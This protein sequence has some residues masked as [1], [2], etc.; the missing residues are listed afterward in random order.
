[1]Q[2]ISLALSL[3]AVSKVFYTTE[4]SD[5]AHPCNHINPPFRR[6]LAPLDAN[7][8]NVSLFKPAKP[9]PATTAVVIDVS[10]VAAVD[11]V[12]LG[13]P[14]A[15]PLPPPSLSDLLADNSPPDAAATAHPI[16]PSGGAPT[17]AVSGGP[18]RILD[19]GAPTPAVPPSDRRVALAILGCPTH[20]AEREVP[21]MAPT[22]HDRAVGDQRRQGT[23]VVANNGDESFG[24]ADTLQC[25][26]P[27]KRG[28][29]MDL[30]DVA[31]LRDGL[32]GQD[33]LGKNNGC[34]RRGEV[35]QVWPLSLGSTFVCPY[36]SRTPL[37]HTFDIMT[38]AAGLQA[39]PAL[40]PPLQSSGRPSVASAAVPK[41]K[42][43]GRAVDPPFP[44]R[45]WHGWS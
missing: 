2:I 17:P 22:A 20:T 25:Y 11:T 18:P 34:I 4:T 13:T 15:M 37:C 7:A 45:R 24:D 32:F 6:P 27:L 1:M 35:Y 9:A 21:C 23:E 3:L 8:A 14:A 28:D 44:L 26:P 12:P 16:P 5:M 29:T 10:S 39:A 19:S 43:S 33:F 30:A 42:A 36:V 38:Y 40:D 41:G 31:A